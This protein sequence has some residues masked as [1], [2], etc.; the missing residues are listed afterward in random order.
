[1]KRT[2]RALALATC[3]AIGL[4]ALAGC[5]GSPAQGS[6]TPTEQ[7]DSKIVLT[8]MTGREVTLEKAA[9]RVIGTHNPSMNM[10]I[11]L[12]GDGKRIAGFGN[13]DMAYGLYDKV[14]P[15][16]NE[17]TSI[18]KGKNINMET[19]ASVKPDLMILPKRMKDLLPKFEELNIPVIILDVEKFDSI[20]EALTLVGK[21]IGKEDRAQ[22]IVKLYDEKVEKI[23]GIAQKATQKP[24]VLMLSG[25]SMTSV[26]T[27]AM[28]QN[29]M[30]ETAGGTNATAGF[31]SDSLWAEVNTE[32]IIKWNP[33]IIYIPAYADYTVQDVLN[34]KDWS[35]IKAVKDK[36]VY[37]F[38][39]ALD[40][41]DYPCASSMLG[42]CWIANNLYPDLYTQEDLMKDVDS[43]YQT[44]YGK[45]F[46]AQELGLK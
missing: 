30:I 11:V 43:F 38:P 13:K 7:A 33:D 34:N 5:G 28:L 40:P 14:A 4:G 16:V 9:E 44:V 39:S 20:K 2:F 25:S 17:V 27:D 37:Q 6:A 41:W 21:A 36:K 35:N 1:M 24:S 42:L 8:D 29:L 45:T 31:A 18:G 15:E 19:V 22:E 10:V 32:Q 12:D 3:A 23:S 26:S 46:T